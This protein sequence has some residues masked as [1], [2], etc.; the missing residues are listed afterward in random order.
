[1]Q[2]HNT[3]RNVGSGRLRPLM[4]TYPFHVEWIVNDHEIV[5]FLVSFA[6]WACAT[7]SMRAV[8]GVCYVS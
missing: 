2:I 8:H 3:D 7:V 5:V 1:M 6:A 4:F